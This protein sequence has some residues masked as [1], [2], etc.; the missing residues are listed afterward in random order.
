MISIR[1]FLVFLSE[2]NC[3]G[4]YWANFERTYLIKDF[5]GAS[6]VISCIFDDK[7]RMWLAY[8]FLYEDTAQ[9]FDYWDRLDTLWQMRCNYLLKNK[10]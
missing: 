2:Y 7:P 9:G 5:N 8:S 6:H 3:L 1:D 4:A 10:D